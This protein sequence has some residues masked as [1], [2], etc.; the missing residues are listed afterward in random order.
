MANKILYS[1][2]GYLS[3]KP[4]ISS[5]DGNFSYSWSILQEFQKRGWD[6]IAVMDRDK[7]IVQSLGKEAFKSFSM[8]KR[9]NV[10][11]KTKFL[12][13][14]HDLPQVDLVLL[15]NRFPTKDNTKNPDEL[16]YSPDLAIQ[17]TIL[18]RYKD[19]PIVLWDL[20][21]K[22]TEDESRFYKVIETSIKPKKGRERVY[23]PF[24]FSEILQFPLRE[25]NLCK[26]LVY[27]GND[28]ERRKDIETKIVPYSI[29]YPFTVQFFGN[30][31]KDEKKELR[32]KWNK[33]SFNGRIDAQG[34]RPS[35]EGAVASP[36]LATED[37]KERGHM[38]MRLLESILFG[39]IPLGFSDFTGINAFLPK[40]L[41]VDM[42]DYEKSMERKMG[43]LFSNGKAYREELRANLSTDLSY[44]HDAKY[45]VDKLLGEGHGQK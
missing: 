37:Y 11:K 31:M 9:Y 32:D 8:D 22:V 23:I 33:I 24:D 14:F 41:I 17:N 45:F 4:G 12:N 35:L 44:Q 42:N 25:V 21:N 13:S 36:L 3:D 28:Y 26:R 16:G 5:P 39:S 40:E 10:Y 2:W 34:F 7:E 6:T 1:F 29:K 30:W 38:T 20:D 18:N 15:E 19:T 43:N 27:C